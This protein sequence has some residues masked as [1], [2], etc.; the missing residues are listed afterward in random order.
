M[1]KNTT[2]K[3]SLKNFWQSLFLLLVLYLLD[4]DDDYDGPHVWSSSFVVSVSSNPWS[5]S[6]ESQQ[7]WWKKKSFCRR[8]TLYIGLGKKSLGYFISLCIDV[9]R[10]LKTTTLKKIL[11][12]W[13]REYVLFFT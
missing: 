12:W 1:L 7:E 4:N 2:I 11:Q 13:H 8:F 5:S 9:G 3:G 10:A 6:K